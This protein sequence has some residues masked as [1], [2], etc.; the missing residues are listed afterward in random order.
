MFSQK[1][2]T[3]YSTIASPSSGVI[4]LG[5]IKGS[6]GALRSYKTVTISVKAGTDD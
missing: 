1:F 6:V 3:F 4:G 5:T 2:E